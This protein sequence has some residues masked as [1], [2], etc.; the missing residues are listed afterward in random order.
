MLT[1]SAPMFLQALGTDALE[2]QL[3]AK[4]PLSA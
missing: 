4:T 3:W 2:N 1:V